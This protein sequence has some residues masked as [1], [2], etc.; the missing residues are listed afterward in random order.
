M[1]VEKIGNSSALPDLEDT[2]IVAGEGGKLWLLPLTGVP[3]P[4]FSFYH[5]TVLHGG[6]VREWS[7]E[8]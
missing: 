8:R 2:T 7:S 5:R 1:K 3:Q 4:R 6:S